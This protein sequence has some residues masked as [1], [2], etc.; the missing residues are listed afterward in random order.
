MNYYDAREKA[1]AVGKP[2]GL[3]HYTAQ[4]DS[5]IYAVGYCA[6]DCPGHPTPDEAREHFRLY[7]LDNARYDGVLRECEVCSAWTQGYAHIPLAME[8]HILCDEHRSRETLDK[9]MHR[10]HQII[11]S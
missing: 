8:R 3:Y 5:H 11:A 6:Q 1:D 4:N 10:V 9:V 7:L 2:T